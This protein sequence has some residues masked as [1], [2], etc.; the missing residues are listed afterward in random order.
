MQRFE[1]PRAGARARSSVWP[2]RER[3]GPRSAPGGDR[4]AVEPIGSPQLVPLE[5]GLESESNRCLCWIGA[6]E[7]NHVQGARA[8]RTTSLHCDRTIFA[9][10]SFPEHSSAAATPARGALRTRAAPAPS[11]PAC[12][13]SA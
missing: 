8:A 3:L 12:R 4:G 10:R 11:G 1:L 7:R 13:P 9:R 6:C 5:E 2:H